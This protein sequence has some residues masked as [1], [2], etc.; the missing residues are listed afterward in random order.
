[1]SPLS[2]QCRSRSERPPLF[3]NFGPLVLNPPPAA[4]GER[5]YPT[6][7]TEF[8]LSS[9]TLD[10]LEPGTGFDAST[11]GPEILLLLHG[12]GTVRDA[13]GREVAC[14][15]GES[16]FVPAAVASYEVRGT[17]LMFRARVPRPQP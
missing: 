11:A 16:V 1:M 4:N 5:R 2:R 8:A 15:P 12:H 17:A 9:V 10:K 3:G 13:A 6:P 14:R 7:A